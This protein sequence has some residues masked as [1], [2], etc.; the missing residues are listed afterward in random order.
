M[1]QLLDGLEIDQVDLVANDTGGAVAQILAARHP[2]RVRSL[3]LT[4]CDTHDGWPPPAFEP[5]VQVAR[6]G[7]L[8][9]VIRA[10]VKDPAAARARFGM[11]FEDPATLSDERVRTFLSP[12][13][14]TPERAAQL[15]RFFR[16]FDCAQT[17]AVEALLREL[18]APTLIVWG[19]A[20]SFFDVKWA[21]WLG[22]T[23]PG[24]RRLVELAGAKLFFPLERPADLATE[25]LVHWNAAALRERL[26]A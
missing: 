3:T 15:E 11:A 25:L 17:V 22:A 5:T 14:E 9:D 7:A 24:T 26:A 10:F 19:T 23:I 18:R 6:Q 20:D 4:N 16:A 13:I 12:L 2:E 8:P 1:L 21:R